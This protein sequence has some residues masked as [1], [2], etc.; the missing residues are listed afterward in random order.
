MEEVAFDF[1]LSNLSICGMSVR[2]YNAKNLPIPYRYHRDSNSS[3]AGQFLLSSA[4]ILLVV[5]TII[6]SSFGQIEEGARKSLIY[7]TRKAFLEHAIV[8]LV[9]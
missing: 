4:V 3:G 5:W 1:N 8:E 2:V 9:L 6:M 7:L